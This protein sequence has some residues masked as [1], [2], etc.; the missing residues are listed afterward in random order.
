[1]T[2]SLMYNRPLQKGNWANTIVWGRTRSLPDN[3]VFNS[4]LLES[5]LRFRVRNYVWTRLENVERSNE[6]ILGEAPLPPGFQEQPVGMVQA[7][8]LGYDR[9]VDLVPHLAS[10]IGGQFTTYGVPDRLKPIYGGHPAGV[11]LFVRL[12]P[13]SGGER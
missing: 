12:R 5:T 4:Y 3:A 9:D 2:A 6:L 11:A 10:A 1:M 13:F 7:Y 8:T